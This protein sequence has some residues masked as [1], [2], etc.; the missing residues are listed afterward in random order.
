MLIDKGVISV[1]MMSDVRRQE[2]LH[3]KP[4]INMIQRN[5]EDSLIS[6]SR[7]LVRVW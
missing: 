2:D 7:N 3:R 6:R 4:V 5:E 1:M